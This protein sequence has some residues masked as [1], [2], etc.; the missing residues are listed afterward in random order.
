MLFYCHSTDHVHSVRAPSH[1]KGRRGVTFLP[2]QITQC[3]NAW[4]LKSGYKRTQIAWKTEAFTILTSNETVKISNLVILKPRILYD[5]LDLQSIKT[6]VKEN[7][8][9]S[10][11][12]SGNFTYLVQSVHND[13]I[14]IE[15]SKQTIYSEALQ[16]IMSH[17]PSRIIL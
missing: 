7:V 14:A 9:P 1:L 3:P 17:R 11:E 4:V 16:C 6:C 12:L 13:F 8:I 15:R 5:D 10:V 2:E